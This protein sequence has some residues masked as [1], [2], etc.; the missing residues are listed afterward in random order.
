MWTEKNGA[1]VKEYKFENFSE[2][3]A[4][5]TRVA[6]LAE[7]HNHHPDWKNSYNKAEIS[8]CS[9]DAGHIVTDKDKVLA[10][11]IDKLISEI[12]VRIQNIELLI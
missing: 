11:E 8:L 12:K 3:F 9:H 7:K 2:A 5:M 10:K 6:F 4:F 1:L